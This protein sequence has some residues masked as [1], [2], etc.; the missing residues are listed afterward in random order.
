MTLHLTRSRNVSSKNC[1]KRV[2]AS[3]TV[4]ETCNGNYSMSRKRRN[5]RMA[6]EKACHRHL[7][8]L[9][10]DKTEWKYS[11]EQ[12]PE[13][14]TRLSKI[15]E[16][17]FQKLSVPFDFVPKFPDNGS[18]PSLTPPRV[19]RLIKNQHR[20]IQF[21]QLIFHGLRKRTI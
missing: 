5:I 6:G 12:I 16:M 4:I 3:L 17:S 1:T 7:L 15:F 21:G 13:K 19:I 9:Q 2:I 10:E 18:R 8:G 20:D 11:M 14:R